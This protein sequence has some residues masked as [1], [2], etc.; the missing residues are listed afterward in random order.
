MNRPDII[1]DP[2]LRFDSF[3]DGKYLPCKTEGRLPLMG[4]NS[5]NAFGSGNNEEFTKA[6][7]DKLIELGLDKLG[8]KYVVLDDGCYKPQRVDGKL[9]HDEVKFKSGF[10][11]MADFLHEKGLKFGMYNDIGDR[12]CSGAEVGT[13][14][15]EAVDAKSYAEWDI[16]FIKVDNC[17]YLWDNATFA[18]PENAKYSFAPDIRS[19]RIEKNSFARTYKATDAFLTEGPAKIDGDHVTFLG[20]FDGTGPDASPNGSRSS[21]LIF[22]LDIIEK[23]TYKLSVEY[24]SGKEE[25]RGNWLQIATDSGIVFDDMLEE[26]PEGEFVTRAVVDIDL[27]VG[28]NVIR[29]MNHRRQENTLSSYNTVRSEL[30]KAMPGKDVA[31]SICEWGKTHPQNWGYKVGDYWR[32]L[33]DITFAVGSAEGDF[34]SCKW[35]DDYTNSI[36]SQYNKCVVMDEFAGLDKG[37]NDPD[38]MVIGMNGLTDDMERTHMSMWCMMNSPLFLGMDLRRVT[39]GDRIYNI[40]SNEDL[41]ALNQDAL[42]IQAKRICTTCA[43]KDP[44]KDYIRDNKRVDVLAKPLSDGSFALA[45]YNLDS[46]TSKDV[47]VDINLIIGKLEDK[48]SSDAAKAISF[49]VIDL[50]TKKTSHSDGRFNSGKLPPHGNLTLKIVPV[51]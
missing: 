14:G 34:G 13:H 1:S 23:G 21:E 33:N 3:N 24:M 22:A 25:G 28:K 42:G 27:V 50:W 45:F 49:N 37:W 40:I 7:A 8:Y 4:W 11:A 17:Y 36:T 48:I 31:F 47:S 38:M 30:C 32:I 51:L 19:I 20:T 43:S 5:W 12:L 2:S 18:N 15:Y 10:K 41:I 6:M 35:E 16:D 44:S 39:K 29:F 46:Q 26:S 9:T